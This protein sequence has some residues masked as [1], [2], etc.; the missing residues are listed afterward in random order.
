[1]SESDPEKVVLAVFAHPDDADFGYGGTIAKFINEGYTGYYIVCTLGDKGS[2]NPETSGPELAALRAQEQRAAARAL[3]VS[4]VFFLG[5]GDAHLVNDLALR[6]RL[7]HHLRELRPDVVFTHDPGYQFASGRGIN[8][9]DHRAA[10]AATIDAVFPCARDPLY[11][12][13]H[14][15]VGLLPHKV[16]ELYLANWHDPDIRIDIS[17]TIDQK[18][19]AAASHASQN[20]GRDPDRVFRER[21]AQIGEAGGLA[22]AEGFKHIILPP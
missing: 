13:E 14:R 1:M 9:P 12:P 6:N 7:V 18:V 8:H 19:A 11:L 20:I 10:G 22:Y 16:K 17:S 4:Q 5:Y 21:A 3:G 2:A 15:R